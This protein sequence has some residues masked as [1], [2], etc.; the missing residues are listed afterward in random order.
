MWHYVTFPIFWQI[1]FS[2]NY[3]LPFKM[4]IL[5]CAQPRWNFELFQSFNSGNEGQENIFFEFKILTL[6][7]GKNPAFLELQYRGGQY[8]RKFFAEN[9]ALPLYV[10]FL[11][12]KWK[13]S[14][15][16]LRPIKMVTR[17]IIFSNPWHRL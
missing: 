14:F 2:T 9:N 12:A 1:S 5:T 7:F 11:L 6:L 4:A 3:Y 17:W 8:R 15:R 13:L 16:Y 10:F